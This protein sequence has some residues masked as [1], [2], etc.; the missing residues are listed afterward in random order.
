M[1]DPETAE[2]NSIWL[3]RRYRDMNRD[4]LERLRQSGK[5]KIETF[6]STH[7]F[8]A[9]QK[10]F[11]LVMALFSRLKAQFTNCNPVLMCIKHKIHPSIIYTT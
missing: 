10:D 2:S 11:M 5:V 1:G 8:S 9:T 6:P 3:L 4:F 7:F